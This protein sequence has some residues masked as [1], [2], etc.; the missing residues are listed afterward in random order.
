MEYDD[1][2]VEIQSK[3]FDVSYV[4]VDD[5]YSNCEEKNV[6]TLLMINIIEILLRINECQI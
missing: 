5:Q 2:Y 6:F 3:I 4:I 1:I